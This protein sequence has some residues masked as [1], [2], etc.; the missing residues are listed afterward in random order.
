MPG[1]EERQPCW[2]CFKPVARY[3]FAG[4]LAGKRRQRHKCPHGVWCISG[5][6]EGAQGFNGPPLGGAH[7]CPDCTAAWKAHW[8]AREN[9]P[10][11][12]SRE[13]CPG[14]G[15]LA[16]VYAGKFTTHGSGSMCPS[17]N[18]PFVQAPAESR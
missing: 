5:S 16:T 12:S 15:S 4:R 9:P 3:S 10:G 1:A 8:Q 17:S 2:A 6:P 18:T 7:Y 11:P 14:C 13:R